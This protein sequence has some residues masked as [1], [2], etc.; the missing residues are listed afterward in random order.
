MLWGSVG[1]IIIGSRTSCDGRINA[2][3][4]VGILQDNFFQGTKAM[5]GMKVSD[6]SSNMSMQSLTNQYLPKFT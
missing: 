5:L 4:H 1:P 6:L 3:M 2:E